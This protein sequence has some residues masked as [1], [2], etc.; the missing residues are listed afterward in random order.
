MNKLTKSTLIAGLVLSVGAMSTLAVSPK[1]NAETV[2]ESNQYKSVTLFS[3]AEIKTLTGL[4]VTVKNAPAIQKAL[5]EVAVWEEAGYETSEATLIANRVKLSYNQS[6]N[7]L[8]K[9][10]NTSNLQFKVT[11]VKNNYYP[12]AEIGVQNH[13]SA[14]EAKKPE[15]SN[16]GTETPE[17]EVPETST[18]LGTVIESNAYKSIT[19]FTKAEIKELTGLELTTKNAAAIQKA[20]TDAKVWEK[21]G[22]EASEAT[23]IANRVKLNASQSLA[24]LQKVANVANLDFKVIVIKNNFPKAEL[25]VQSHGSAPEVEAPETEKPGDSSNAGEEESAEQTSDIRQLQIELDYKKGDI[26]LQYQVNSNG[27]IKAQYKNG[28]TKENFQG[29]KAEEKVKA[30]LTGIDLNSANQSDIEKH[31]VKKL[32][33]GSDYKQFQ[34]QAQFTDNTKVKIKIKK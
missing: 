22:Y 12:K 13:V 17:V 33:A 1:A 25:G 16:P 19:L 7:L 15:V 4:D 6:L 34:L 26:Q 9:M 18:P 23:L 14:P 3:K 24:L 31:V 21:A 20:L 32:N 2:L 5:S 10:A 11:L 28:L 27:T 30:V 8:K 29:A